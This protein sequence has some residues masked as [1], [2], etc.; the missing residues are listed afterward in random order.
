MS[1]EFSRI[2]LSLGLITHALLHIIFCS[3][4]ALIDL[5]FLFVF[6]SVI[7]MLYI[8]VICISFLTVP[9]TRFVQGRGEDPMYF[10][11]VLIIFISPLCLLITTC[12]LV[13]DYYATF[14]FCGNSKM[15]ASVLGVFPYRAS[16][17]LP[18]LH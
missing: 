10:C 11:F 15:V 3:L 6:V 9:V 16:Q 18:N 14:P 17:A 8:T 7:F 12:R 2:F 5:F 13:I 4:I 1:S